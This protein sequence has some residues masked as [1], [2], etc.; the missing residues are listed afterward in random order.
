[1]RL[2]PPLIFGSGPAREAHATTSFVPHLALVQL[3]KMAPTA[4]ET[5]DIKRFSRLLGGTLVMTGLATLT[6]GFVLLDFH[7]LHCTGG[8]TLSRP[9]R[10][11]RYFTIQYA[12]LKGK[13]PVARVAVVFLALALAANVVVI[14]A[15]LVGVRSV[16]Q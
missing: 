11:V 15:I 9:G 10:F 6:L 3:L 14:F 4:P 13:F 12:L 1:M 16:T 7:S 8:L 5:A 2:L